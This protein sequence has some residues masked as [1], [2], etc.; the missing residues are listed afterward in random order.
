[1]PTHV[2]AS[3]RD[4]NARAAHRCMCC[5]TYCRRVRATRLRVRAYLRQCTPLRSSDGARRH[6]VAELFATAL[7]AGRAFAK[8]EPWLN[9][10]GVRRSLG[11]QLALERVGAEAEHGC[12]ALERSE[13][14]DLDR[15]G[16]DEASKA[17]YILRH[18][19]RVG[20]TVFIETG[21]WYGETLARV[22]GHF[23][24]LVSIEISAQIAENARRRFADDRHVE[25]VTGRSEAELPLVLAARDA[26]A[27]TVLWLDGHFSGSR[28]ETAKGEVDSPVL[29]ELDA[30]LRGVADDD[31]IIIDDARL[32]RGFDVCRC[33]AQPGARLA[34]GRA[35]APR[36]AGE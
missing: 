32:Y 23:T 8:A 16:L 1:M 29:A 21:T 17:A 12:R 14:P 13:A 35:R 26:S 30:A 20:A 15:E 18:A 3:H 24:R 31:V 19:R 4:R 7:S 28:Y 36:P 27:P 25:I 6:R 5:W 9:G 10:A 33:R 2:A 34:S 22:K 11:V